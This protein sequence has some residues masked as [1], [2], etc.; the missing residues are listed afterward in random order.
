[1]TE[2]R[3][4]WFE[5]KKITLTRLDDVTWV[6]AAGMPYIDTSSDPGRG[7]I[8]EFRTPRWDPYRT[9]TFKPHDIAFIKEQLGIKNAGNIQTFGTFVKNA[10]VDF[11]IGSYAVVAF[12]FVLGIGGLGG[13][14]RWATMPKK[15]KE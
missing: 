9:R 1:M 6:D 14:I 11:L 4:I 7:G 8:G 13:L 2:T 10:T 3:E 12:P 5:G 15:N